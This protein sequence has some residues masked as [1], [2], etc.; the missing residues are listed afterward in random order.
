MVLVKKWKFLQLFFLGNIDLENVFSDILER[1]SAF[2]VYK[3][4]KF[5]R[6]KN[7]I[8]PNGLTHAFGPQMAIFPTLFFRQ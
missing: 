1:K 8:F 7:D 5:K 3:N 6:S 2:P 4:K